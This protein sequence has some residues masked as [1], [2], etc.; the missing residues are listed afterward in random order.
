MTLEDDEDA[1]GGGHAPI[2]E[3]TRTAFE[4][5]VAR[6]ERR[7]R[8]AHAKLRM[9]TLGML[10]SSSRETGDAPGDEIDTRGEDES[11]FELPDEGTLGALLSG[12]EVLGRV[13]DLAARAAAAIEA[14]KPKGRK[15]RW[16]RRR[17]GSHRHRNARVGG[18]HHRDG[19]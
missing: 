16:R 11:S 5:A 6:R 2:D 7:T 17:R 3:E 15:D 12:G 13:D 14:N 19:S 10:P 8:E 9:R 4:T 1:K 18:H